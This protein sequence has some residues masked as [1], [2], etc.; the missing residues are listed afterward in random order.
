[1]L[2]NNLLIDEEF[3]KQG[4]YPAMFVKIVKNRTGL[5]TGRIL[6]Q[7]TSSKLGFKSLVYCKDWDVS[8]NK[9]YN[10]LPDYLKYYLSQPNIVY[11]NAQTNS[12]LHITKPDD[13][14]PDELFHYIVN[15]NFQSDNKGILEKLQELQ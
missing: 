2:I 1:V 8:L 3:E 5:L 13:L 6:I 10:L 11:K 14:E 9:M 12:I 15:Q 7:S 4:E